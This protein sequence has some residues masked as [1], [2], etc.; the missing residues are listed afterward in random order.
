MPFT[1]CQICLCDIVYFKLPHVRNSL[2]CFLA[3]TWFCASIWFKRVSD[4]WISTKFG[5]LNL[6]W[7]TSY[8][9]LKYCGNDR[10]LYVMSFKF[11]FH[12]QEC[13]LVCTFM[14]SRVDDRGFKSRKGQEILLSSKS[15]AHPAS[16]SVCIGCSLSGGKEA[17]VWCRSLTSI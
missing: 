2:Q 7:E 12:S 8:D 4:L 9:L 1:Y 17:G 16:Q 6:Y 3:L 13:N 11:A 14:L 5:R 15:Q 10:A